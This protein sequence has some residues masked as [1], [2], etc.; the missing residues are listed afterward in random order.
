M[1]R[2]EAMRAVAGARANAAVV[3]GPGANCGLMYE[4][5]DAPATIYNMDMGYAT[6]VALGVALARPHRPVLAVEGEGSFYAG[7]TVLSTIWR[8]KPEN[9]VVV[10]LDNGVWGTGDGLEPSATSCGVDLTQLALAAGWGAANVHA[11]SDADELGRHLSAAMGGKGP[12]F[13]VGKTDPRADAFLNAPNRPRPG[14][15]LLECAVLMRAD[16]KREG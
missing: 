10:V 9:L 16:L 4:R 2:D 1:N 13:I 6:S 14:R 11:P 3:M 8:M 5:A 12:H 7:S 15:H